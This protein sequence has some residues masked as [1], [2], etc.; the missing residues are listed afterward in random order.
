MANETSVEKKYAD[1]LEQFLEKITECS[2]ILTEV[3][4]FLIKENPKRCLQEIFV[5]VQ[6]MK[7]QVEMKTFME[8]INDIITNKGKS[9]QQADE[10]KID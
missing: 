6:F 7:I 3:N 1:K 2:N 10:T 8:T 9:E 5:P 4:S